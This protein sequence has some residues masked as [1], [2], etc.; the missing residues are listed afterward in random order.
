MTAQPRSPNPDEALTL[1]RGQSLHGGGMSATRSPPTDV[2]I[3]RAW[4]WSS[5]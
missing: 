4:R 1:T 2:P 5:G 3:G